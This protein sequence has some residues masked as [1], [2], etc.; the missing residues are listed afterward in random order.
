MTTTARDQMLARIRSGLQKNRALLE[1]E[2]ARAPHTPPPFVHPEHDDLAAQF[3]TE[4]AK[5]EGLPHRC[6]DAEAALDAIEQILEQHSATATVAWDVEAINLPGMKEVLER[7]GVAVLDGD[8]RH[9]ADRAA[10]IQVLEPAEVCISG[11][12]VGIAESG[13]LLLVSGAG[14][15]RLASLLAP[16]HI[17]VLRRSQ[18]VRGLGEALARMQAEYGAVFDAHSNITLITGPSRT[19]DIE[20]TLT[21]G[22]HGPREIHVLLVED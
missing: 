7:H 6:D 4:L 15:G 10:Q 12:F 13:S 11:A 1:R 3:A 18:L 16:V 14:R 5:L 22:I 17:A 20:M 19:A 2:A 8:I 21:L 9:A